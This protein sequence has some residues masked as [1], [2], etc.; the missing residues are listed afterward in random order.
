MATRSSRRSAFTLIE[1][2][3]VI[4]IIAILIGL[5]LPAVQ[6]VREAAARTR[7]Q[8]NLKQIGLGCHNFAST[9]GILP[10][11]LLGDGANYQSANSGPYMGALAWI[12]PYVELDSVWNAIATASKQ[13]GGTLSI[14][15]T[16]VDGDPWWV[17]RDVNTNRTVINA[18]R[19]RIPLYKCPSDDV[20]E[21]FSNSKAILVA[22]VY[23]VINGNNVTWTGSGFYPGDLGPAGIGL[24]NYMGVAGMFATVDGNFFSTPNN[25][26]GSSAKQYRGPMLYVTRAEQQTNLVT[27]DSLTA[28]DGASNTLLFGE[29]I[30]SSYPFNPRDVGFSWIASGANVT[31][32]TIPNSLSGVYWNDW[33]SKHAGGLVNFVMAD[34]SVRAIRPPG[35]DNTK[36]QPFNPPTT[37]EQA[38]YAISG[39]S[40]G[41]NTK[42]DG[43]TN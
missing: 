37:A 14:D 28:A 3:V 18:A 33:S 17:A 35:R 1:L 43:I 39:F 23:I 9:H 6:K 11:G 42:S 21:T 13:K 26:Q 7:C 30:T 12:L 38:F 10:P 36:D 34:G 8:N 22:L 27:L 25:L 31:F 15:P 16:K 40:D 20:E 32:W 19:I 2:L 4:A 24:T 29:M 5:L 41:D